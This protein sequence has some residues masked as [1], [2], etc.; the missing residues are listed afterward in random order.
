MIAIRA[1]GNNEI[2]IGHV[3]RCLTVAE[4]LR[5]KGADVVF[6]LADDSCKELVSDRG[7]Q[8]VI[9][10]TKYDR[11]EEETEILLPALE[12][13]GAE[14]VIVDSYYVTPE[15]LQELRKK[16]RTVYLD[17][18]NRF[19]YPVDLLINYNVFAKET[20]YPYAMS[21][22]QDESGTVCA[23]KKQ[24]R[25]VLLAGP[26]YAP[27]RKEFSQC[28]RSSW[29]KAEHCLISL[30]GSDAYS[31]SLK[32]SKKMLE[33][34]DLVLHVVCGPF[35]RCK[36][37][38][39]ELEKEEA[40]IVIHENV[41]DMWNLM[42]QCDIAISA[43]GSTMCELA[44]AG[45]PAVT[46]SFVENQRYIAEEFGVR[47]AA[48]FVEHYQEENEAAFLEGISFAV[49]ELINHEDLRRQIA[50]NARSLVDGMGALRLAQAILL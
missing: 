29:D 35:N 17:D 42:K 18:L 26:N 28:R 49:S 39:R 12:E 16:F 44:T 14:T 19:E 11:L 13:G 45:L 2:G 9:L 41:A 50:E 10:G 48:M 32:I 37:E 36:Q 33:S 15:Y 38:L 27:V 21:Y 23:Q 4:A 34:T 8:W 3:M 1:D 47:K 5:D 31:L 7:F 6:Y 20:D 40:R 25:T 43:A 24:E 46:F 22:E 30:G